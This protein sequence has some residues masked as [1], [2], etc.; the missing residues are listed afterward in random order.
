MGKKFR[1]DPSF[2]MG[3]KQTGSLDDCR[4]VLGSV[5]YEKTTSYGTGTKRGPAAIIAASNEL[6]LYDEETGL[7][8]YALGINT[9]PA[10]SCK[11]GEAQVFRRIEQYA[12]TAAGTG[13]FPVFIGGEH[14]L[15]QALLAPFI[16]RHEKLS[17]LHIDAHADL[18]D[19]YVGSS[20]NHA[21]ALYPASLRRRVV[22]AGIRS[23]SDDEAH[24]LNTGLVTTFF[25]HSNRDQKKLVKDVL[26][27]L[28]DTVYI[29]IDVDGFDP[30]V[31][32]GTGTPQ[33]GGFGWYEGL[34]LLRAVF[35]NKNVVGADVVEVSPQKGSVV[36]EFNAAKLIY[37][38]FSYKAKYA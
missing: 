38:L 20:R 12:E 10:V 29:T 16:R 1:Q 9:L 5:P 19:S 4:F 24:R 6:E 17:I 36:S 23:V 8:T 32:P 7:V 11:G 31:F 33:P 30:S 25:M 3:L 13:A 35:R 18:R 27:A 26:R 37:R 28:T 2:F 21:C 14:S 22:Q 34:D 15:T